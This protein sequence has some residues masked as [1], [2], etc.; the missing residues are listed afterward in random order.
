MR[1]F[2]LLMLCFIFLFSDVYVGI[3]GGYKDVFVK[4][5]KKY[6]LTR[7]EK[8]RV[9]Y[10]PMGVLIAQAKMNTLD[11]ILGDKET[12]SK[13][14]FKDFKT[15][16]YSKLV[17]LTKKKLNT[18]KEINYLK[19]L[20]VPNP[21]STTYGKAAK[22]A[23]EKLHLHPKTIT[24][25]LM[26]QGIN[27]LKI[28][29]CDGA[30]VNKT[31]EI[32]LKHRFNYLEVPQRYYRPIVIGF[33]LLHESCGVNDFINFLTSPEIKTYLKRYGI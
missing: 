3:P 6:N 29:Q 13:N 7:K 14:G 25:S 23:F 26:P 28:S 22:E 4:L 12:L 2:N 18:L 33:C 8:V 15:L 20:A 5:I 1:V 30:V 11:V 27:Y 32:L 21:K 10:G 17:I 24:V 16:G 31:Q 19:R 9:I